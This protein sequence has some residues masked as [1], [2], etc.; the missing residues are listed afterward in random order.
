M[1][2]LF[3]IL[4]DSITNSIFDG[5]I[6]QP[7]LERKKKNADLEIIIVSFE[8]NC[9]SPALKKIIEPYTAFK[10][11]LLKKYPF[12]TR[13][14]LLPSIYQLN[15][16]LV[17]YPA[18]TLIARG[19]IA[20]YI[21]IKAAQKT[22]CQKLTIQAR[23]ALTE[24]YRYTTQGT[25][26][27]IVK[28]L[29]QWRT[30]QFAAIESYVYRKQT[31]CN[32]PVTI[33][34]VSSALKDYLITA[35]HADQASILIA[36]HDIPAKFSDVQIQEWR[37]QIR[38]ELTLNNQTLVY[39]YNGSLKP[40]QCPQ[41]TINYFKKQFLHNNDIFLLI[42]TQ[43]KEE[44]ESLLQ[45]NALEPHCYLVITVK[46]NEIYRYLAA[47]DVGIIF[48]EKNI[49]NWVSRPTKIVEYQAVGL[50]IV[51]NETIALFRENY[52]IY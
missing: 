25:A 38:H 32:F 1:P 8:K 28:K 52:K 9:N 11:I 12:I 14:T 27:I 46:H 42:L 34:A 5:Q 16:I 17:T 20:G 51:H 21:C 4:N 47:C 29:Q 19:P 36:Q 35:Y 33:E 39:C 15:K 50:P 41:E 23:G 6:A 48:R 22:N 30:K 43:D 3:F 18:Y 40:W 44:F 2:Y 10:F 7:L 45:G 31:H 13:L 26:N 49:L 37:K 24:E